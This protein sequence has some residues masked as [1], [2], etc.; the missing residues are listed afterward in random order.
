MRTLLLFPL[1]FFFVIIISYPRFNQ[2]DIFGIK[3]L[4]GKAEDY[5]IVRGYYLSG[6][7][8]D[9]L[10]SVKYYRGE[11]KRDELRTPYVYRALVPFYASFLPI[12]D[13]LTALNVANIIF[14]L[15]AIV[16]LYFLLLSIGFEKIY[17]VCGIYLFGISF[18]TFYYLTF[19]NVDSG[20]ILFVIIGLNAI[21]KR[22]NLL[23]LLSLTLGVLVKETAFI[24][25]PFYFAYQVL[26]R[27]Y[28]SLKGHNIIHYILIL[29]IP[30]SAVCFVRVLF[31][32]LPQYFWTPSWELIYSNLIRVKAYFSPLLTLGIP[33]IVSIIFLYLYY[34]KNIRVKFS[35][36]K[37]DIEQ[38]NLQKYFILIFVLSSFL[39]LY[40]YLAAVADGRAF[41][42]MFIVSIILTLISLTYYKK[43]KTLSS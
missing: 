2:Q 31:S 30:I 12:D 25:I 7:A 17:A 18:F 23:F 22:N 42:P 24:L 43:R 10:Y 26:F 36:R 20:V 38:L 28:L 5:N 41:M 32:D 16:S 6:D 19:G 15:I 9:Y 8:V 21:I 27:K 39:G 11:L 37:S 33:G 34:K 13:P 35:E 14:F 29:I 1:L 40:G 4:S 3:K